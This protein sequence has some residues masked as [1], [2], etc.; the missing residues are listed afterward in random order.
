MKVDNC[1]DCGIELNEKNQTREHIPAKNVFN[2]YPDGY[3]TNRITV[4]A[5]LSCNNKYSKSDN[6]IRDVIGIINN[7]NIQQNELTRQAV[8]SLFRKNDWAERIS[9]NQNQP[10][11]LVSFDYDQI[12]DHHIKNFKGLFYHK[13]GYNLPK[14]F[15]VTSIGEGDENDYE[16]MKFREILFQFLNDGTEWEVSGHKDIFQYKISFFTGERNK[17]I[18][19]D[20]NNISSPEIIIAGLIYHKK[21]RPIVFAMRKE[22]LDFLE[23]KNKFA[24]KKVQ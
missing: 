20:S 21:L 12:K 3:K 8:K 23:K 14:D 13:F 15:E 22:H 4:S 18:I 1:Y 9:V 7:N 19:Q 24:N 10:P 17:K 16:Q 2:G 11:F 6:V 5:C